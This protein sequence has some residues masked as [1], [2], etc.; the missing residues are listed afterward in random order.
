MLHHSCGFSLVNL[1]SPADPG[2]PEPRHTVHYT[3]GITSQPGSGISAESGRVEAD[4]AMR[5][6]R[7]DV[8]AGYRSLDAF[9]NE[10]GLNPIRSRP[11]FQLL[12]MDLAMPDEVFAD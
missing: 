11:D 7:R 4:L 2:L 5:W 10:S 9:R 8:A 6:L 3:R 12:M 1:G